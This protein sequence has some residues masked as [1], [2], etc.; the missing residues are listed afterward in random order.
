[1]KEHTWGRGGKYQYFMVRLHG[2]CTLL[3]Q[4]AS[5]TL[6][7]PDM[8][9][10]CH[11][12]T[13]IFLQTLPKGLEAHGVFLELAYTR[14]MF[15][16]SRWLKFN[17]RDPPAGTLSGPDIPISCTRC[18]MRSWRRG[19]TAGGKAK[20]AGLHWPE[21]QSS[22]SQKHTDQQILKQLD[23]HHSLEIDGCTTGCG[24]A[25]YPD[26]NPLHLFSL[27]VLFIAQQVFSPRSLLELLFQT[28]VPV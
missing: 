5:V 25:E 10:I 21:Q 19:S 9:W 12:A 3:L 8:S 23:R 20:P 26:P 17:Q 28:D 2:V 27:S 11:F 14:Q 22:V 4:P 1:M 7:V 15:T 18:H 16:H 6:Q 13:E 24:G